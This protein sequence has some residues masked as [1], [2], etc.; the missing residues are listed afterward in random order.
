MFV[1]DQEIIKISSKLRLRPLVD[2]D[3]DLALIWYSNENILWYSEN[4][5][6]PYEKKDIE[7]MYRFLRQ[8]GLVYVIEYKEE[9]WTGIGDVTLS[10]NTMPMILMPEYQGLGIGYQVIMT[11][12]DKGKKMGYEK[13]ALSGIY[14]YNERSLAMYKKCGFKETHR[15]DKKIYLEKML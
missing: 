6:K 7:N 11:L 14:L 3:Y 5:N 10:E 8:K 1:Y 13:I 15:D 9:N 12:L 2:A 4:R